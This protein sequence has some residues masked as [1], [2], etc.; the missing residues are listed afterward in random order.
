MGY[1]LFGFR[2]SP[3]DLNGVAKQH[4]AAFFLDK[5]NLGRDLLRRPVGNF[6]PHTG[7]HPF[8]ECLLDT[9]IGYAE[10][11]T[12]VRAIAPIKKCGLD[13]DASLQ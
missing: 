3:S 11:Q 1:Q 6:R 8:T 10:P 9:A 4:F 7:C 5:V 13:K 12:S 2:Q